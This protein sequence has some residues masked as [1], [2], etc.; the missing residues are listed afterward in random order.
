MG[1]ARALRSKRPDR[2]EPVALVALAWGRDPMRESMPAPSEVDEVSRRAPELRAGLR[3]VPPAVSALRALDRHDAEAARAQV[4]SGLAS[5]DSPGVAVWL[6]AMALALDDEGLAR[7]AALA[8]LQLSAVYE[9]A[10][11]LAARVALHSGRLD[12]ALKATEE[13]DSSSAEVA[14][15]RAAAAYERAD[16]DGL[17]RSLEALSSL[18]RKS[19][20]VTALALAPDVLSGRVA[21]DGAKLIAFADDDAPWSDLIGMDIALDTGNLA[22]ASKIASSWGKD[23]EGRGLRA[24]RL[25]RL[26]RYEGRL[27]AADAL[28][29]VAIEHGT[30]TPRVL[31]ERVFCLVARSRF[32]EVAPLLGRYPLVLG[33]L[34]TW[35]NAYATA[36]GG[37]IDAAKGKTASIDPPPSTAPL[38]ARTVAASA[39]A[40]MKDRKRGT[41]YVRALLSAGSNNPDAVAAALALGLRRVNH[42]RRRPPTYE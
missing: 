1:L 27:D 6:G 23:A 2:A 42:G 16:A 4:I 35:L 36:A 22:T 32:T 38:D 30:V 20:I 11:A 17:S 18:A 19:S 37:N 24:L 13:L 39:L 10:R 14:V 40:A 5:V 28:S 7:R 9:P 29:L 26:A 21:L 15:V 34:A 25:A 12:E 31:W 33:P 3:F 41:D 8:A